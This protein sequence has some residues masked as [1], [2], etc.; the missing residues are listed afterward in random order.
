MQPSNVWPVSDSRGSSSSP[1]PDQTARSSCT[2][3][4]STGAE[5]PPLASQC[6]SCDRIRRLSAARERQW[7]WTRSRSCGTRRWRCCAARAFTGWPLPSSSA[8][9]GLA[10]SCSS[11]STGARCCSTASC[12]RPGSTWSGWRGPM[13]CWARRA[14]AQPTSWRGAWIHLQADV[15]ASV[16]YRRI[17]R[18]GLG[19]WLAPYRG[20]KTYAVWSL[21]DPRP[22]AAQTALL[23]RRL[24][25]GPRATPPPET[26]R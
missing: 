24:L 6:A 15:L 22:F 4:T 23:A 19:E 3:S 7:W 9:R 5:S 20:P 25:A 11:R 1:F 18:L 14:E 10:G 17:E 16:R 21:R 2:A 13:W 8:T 26:S 12:R